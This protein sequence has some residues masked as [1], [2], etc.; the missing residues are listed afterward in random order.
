M[1]NSSVQLTIHGTNIGTTDL[2]VDVPGIRVTRIIRTDNPNYLFVNLEI[3][4]QTKPQ[5]IP[6]TF[7]GTKGTIQSTYSLRKRIPFNERS[8]GLDQTDVIYLIMPDRFAN[9]NQKNDALP[10][11]HQGVD[12]GNPDM[13]HGGDLQGIIDHLDYIR[14]LGVTAIWLTPVQENNVKIYSYHGYGMTDHY[15]IDPRLGTN[16]DYSRLVEEAHKRG[17]KVVFDVVF[18]QVGDQHYFIRDLPMYDWIHQFDTFTRTNYATSSIMDP[19]AAKSDQLLATNG[20]FDTYMPDMNQKNPFVEQYLKQY[21]T[22]WIEYANLDAVRFDTYP[23]NDQEMLARWARELRAEYP[24]MLVFGEI[25]LGDVGPETEGYWLQ[26]SKTGPQSYLGGIVDFPMYFSM[27]NAFRKGGSMRSLHKTLSQDF[28]Y[29]DPTNNVLLASNHDVDRLLSALGGNANR[30]KMFYTVLM[31]MRGI[32]QVYYGD[33]H[34]MDGYNDGTSDGPRRK[35]FP[36]GWASDTVDF[37]NPANLS[38]ARSDFYKFSKSLLDWRGANPEILTG[39]LT[40]FVPQEEVYVYFRHGSGKAAMVIV[41]NNETSKT[42]QLDRFREILKD[43]TTGRN[44]LTKEKIA[45]ESE[46]L[47]DPESVIIVEF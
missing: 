35:D 17:L 28:L 33:E 14:G 15:K 1:E 19:H 10:G 44:A 31:T 6:M 27:V 37:F 9:G 45:L 29:T 43:Y 2:T 32:P 38:P 11:Y 30:M 22:W 12:R 18:N 24:N 41:N 3:S 8:I 7:K 26:D 36:G 46:L 16:A 39:K 25:L 34:L 40:H 20:W 13:R 42:L 23:Y 21:V 5:D 47:L 4:D